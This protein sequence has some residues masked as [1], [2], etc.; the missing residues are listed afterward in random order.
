VIPTDGRP[1]LPQ[2]IRL[3]KGDSRGHWEGDTLVIETTNFSAKNSFRGASENMKLTERLRRMDA[4]TLIYQFTVDDPSTWER[5]WTVEIPVTKS[6]GQ[7]FE[8]ACHEGNYGMMGALAGARAEE[9]TAEQT[10]K[11]S[12]E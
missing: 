7:L 4:D 5:P 9:K 12:K 11:G 1:H 6:Q 8:Y 2:D 10:R 3:W